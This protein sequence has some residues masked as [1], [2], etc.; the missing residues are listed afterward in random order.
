[1]GGIVGTDVGMIVGLGVS[2]GIKV[3]AGIRKRVGVASK[4][5]LKTSLS[6][7]KKPITE[8]EAAM[9]KKRVKINIFIDI[10]I[11][12]TDYTSVGN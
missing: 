12:R 1:M 7:P 9:V 5:I 2:V 6:L 11:N 10:F 3:G 8:S 4:A